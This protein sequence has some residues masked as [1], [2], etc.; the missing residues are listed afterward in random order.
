MSAPQPDASRFQF[1][2]YQIPLSTVLLVIV[3]MNVFTW[4]LYPETTAEPPVSPKKLVIRLSADKTEVAP[5]ETVTI[6]ISV[7]NQGRE[8]FDFH[9][10]DT[11][12][13]HFTAGYLLYGVTSAP[14]PVVKS[15]AHN[16]IGADSAA[17]GS[18]IPTNAYCRGK[19]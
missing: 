9:T 12:G 11:L 5:G 16:H 3:M 14:K 2:W 10:G 15:G 13:N 4:A 18:W 1:R 6:K 17:Q 19:K 8:T 7:I